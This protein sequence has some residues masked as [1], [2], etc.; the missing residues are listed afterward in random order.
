MNAV[1]QIADKARRQL[2]WLVRD[3][4]PGRVVVR[5]VHGVRMQL[6]WSHR[7]P[8]YT[9][10]ESIYGRNLMELA[11]ALAG[12]ED[13]P[14]HVLDVGANVGDTALMVLH[15][16]DARV[17]CVEADPDYLPW[18]HRNVDG[19]DRV[20]VVESLLAAE[21]G[22]ATVQ[23]VR[24]GGTTRFEEVDEGGSGLS[25]VS[26]DQLRAD[27]PDFANLRLV[28]SDTDGYDVVLVPAVAR[29]WSASR[30]VLFFE[31][32]LELSRLA[33]NDPL[34]V[35]KHLADLGYEDV[36]V[37]H[38][39]G[40]ALGRTTVHAVAAQTGPLEERV[41]RRS[42]NYWDV[43]V[44]HHDDPVGREVLAALVSGMLASG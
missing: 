4:F 38:G 39:G 1:R 27:H 25:T 42:R 41:G 16:A 20:A 34:A 24:A 10:G 9:S 19:D 6:P 2:G 31:Y 30:P 26:A 35:W 8:D 37:W 11:E 17:L 18:L 5:D 13:A 22:T 36:A 12:R 32:D 14:L 15:A 33:G 23:A 7:L 21:T 43:A 44:A 29:T 3:R 40:W 28:K